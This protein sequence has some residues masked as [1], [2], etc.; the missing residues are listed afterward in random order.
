MKKQRD[1][2]EFYRPLPSLPLFG[3]RP[4]GRD[5]AGK[6]PTSAAYWADHDKLPSEGI[7]AVRLSCGRHERRREGVNLVEFAAW[8][9]GDAHSSRPRSVCPLLAAVLER[10]GDAMTDEERQTTGRQLALSAAWTSDGQEMLR[11]RT[12]AA[13][14]VDETCRLGMADEVA[15]VVYVPLFEESRRVSRLAKGIEAVDYPRWSERL[16]LAASSAVLFAGLLSAR[17]PDEWL[18]RFGSVFAWLAALPSP[19]PD[20]DLTGGRRGLR[21]FPGSEGGGS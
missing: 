19:G 17:E 5:A 18:G 14:C 7:A 3:A 10:L 9:A 12:L 6:S 15:A 8:C 1:D 13:W 11:C 2:D 20:V 21:I 16:E 4:E